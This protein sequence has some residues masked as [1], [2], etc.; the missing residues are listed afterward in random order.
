MSVHVSRMC[1]AHKANKNEQVE[2]T[3]LKLGQDSCRA[4]CINHGYIQ[5]LELYSWLLGNSMNK[6]SWMHNQCIGMGLGGNLAEMKHIKSGFRW[7]GN[8]MKGYVSI[9]FVQ[10]KKMFDM[11]LGCVCPQIYR[12]HSFQTILVPYNLWKCFENYPKLTLSTILTDSLACWKCIKM[13]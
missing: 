5:W 2:E 10:V 8:H 6:S 11:L 12:W 1:L 9:A 7:S 3:H 13:S 4:P